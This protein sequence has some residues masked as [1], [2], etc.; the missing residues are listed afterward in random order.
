VKE[1]LLVAL[2]FILGAAIGVSGLVQIIN[3]VLELF[4]F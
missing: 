1:F 2:G 3:K 4:K